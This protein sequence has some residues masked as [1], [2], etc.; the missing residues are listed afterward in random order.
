MMMLSLFLS[1]P[2]LAFESTPA[3][4][5]F[6]IKNR[7]KD[8]FE[9]IEYE[10][11][12]PD[13]LEVG[14]RFRINSKGG[15]DIGMNAAS[16][17][18]WPDVLTH[19]LHGFTEGGWFELEA[20]IPVTLDIYVDF[21]GLF[22]GSWNLW[23][24]G[25]YMRDEA[26][27]D[28]LLLPGG[29]PESV[30][31]D[32]QGIGIDQIIIPVSIVTGLSIN[33]IMDVFPEA[34]STITGIQVENI[35]GGD[36]DGSIKSTE[37]ELTQIDVPTDDPG[38]VDFES[39]WRGTLDAS[40][41]IVFAPAVE[42]CVLGACFEVFDIEV[43]VDMVSY[44]EIV[45][46]K[47]VDYEHPLPAINV[48]ISNFDFGEVELGDNNNLPIP[49]ENIGQLPLEGTATIEGSENITVFPDYFFANSG[50]TDGVMIT[51]T[52]EAVSDESAILV[53]ESNDPQQPRIEIPLLGI[54]Y[55]EAIA[56]D[57]G[58]FGDGRTES[59]KS[60]GC[61]S[62]TGANGGLWLFGL[63]GLLGLRRRQ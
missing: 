25:L 41:A 42:A 58:P 14:L 54:G 19:D 45:D 20:D 35:T 7:D 8:V 16:E 56:E 1:T 63:L 17:I 22:T 39:T 43:P 3:D 37:A 40:L 11:T 4:F 18:T 21:A 23:T 27:F 32:A 6:E 13:G 55:E 36:V 51:F 9:A 48:D 61:S 5:V 26:I 62:S 50:Q 28:G 46:F 34:T 30:T 38:V 49:I 60:C 57:T 29:T 47:E 31:V 33:F 52:P 12:V 2:A 59:I 10:I 24:A 15:A 53:L 44:S